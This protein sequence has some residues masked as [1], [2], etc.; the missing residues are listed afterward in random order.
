MKKALLT[1]FFASVIWTP[2]KSQKIEASKVLGGYQFSQNGKILNTRQMVRIMEPNQLA[3]PM[4]KKARSTTT[5]ASIIG[6]AGGGAMGYSLGG[7]IGGGKVNWPLLGIGA[8][9]IGL[10][11]PISINAKNQARRAVQ[12]YNSSLSVRS[13]R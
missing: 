11:I 4:M 3:Y 12:Q 2:S 13:I 1:L 10:G 6:F 9:I 8:G 7:A 5:I